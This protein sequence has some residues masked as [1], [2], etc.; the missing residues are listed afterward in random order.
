MRDP[1]T[2]LGVSRSAS[3]DEIKRA[4]R[5][6]AKELHPDRNPDDKKI[7]E[8]FK[9]VSAAYHILGDKDLRGKFDRGE[10]DAGGQP[11]AP[12]FEY[13]QG[14]GPG[15]GPGGAGGFSFNFGGGDADDILREFGDIFGGRARARGRTG[16]RRGPD[17]TYQL[18]VDF[19][20]AAA[21]ATR[22][23]T[24]P[25]GKSLD[26]RIPAGIDDGQVI[27]LKGQGGDNPWGGEAGD[28]LIEVKINP[29][30]HFRREGRDIHLRLPIGLHEAV[31]GAKVQAPTV[32]GPVTLTLP[33]GSNAGRTLRL[34]GKGLA[35]SG[36]QPAGDQYVT[37]EVVLPD[38]PD[39]ELEAF[40][41]K[42]ADKHD[43]DVRR[44]V[45]LG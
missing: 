21:G 19:L 9:E 14:A 42:W 38:E 43:Y 2:V 16:P 24:L 41:R 22:R 17:L 32:H 4:Y 13:A 5:A 40:I 28:A 23:V 20:D 7:G 25:G 18:A 6:L 10:I 36:G 12:R 31:L 44:R 33:K 11:R 1:Y 29:H 30:P 35:A 15:G 8:R 45:G 3:D 26:V 34:K 39:A 37:L 27:R